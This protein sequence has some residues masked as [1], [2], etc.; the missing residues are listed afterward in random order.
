MPRIQP[1]PARRLVP[2]LSLL[3]LG[4]CASAVGGAIVDVALNAARKTFLG[5]ATENYGEQY[6]SDFDKLLTAL[7][8]P[9]EDGAKSAIAGQGAPTGTPPAGS[10]PAAAGAAPAPA[11]AGGDPSAP[12]WTPPPPPAPLELE[13]AILKEEL[14]DGRSIAMP[15]EDGEV[16]FDR[17]GTNGRGDN[18]KLTFRAN[19][20]CWVYVIGVDGTGW[21]STLFP[22]SYSAELNPVQP[23]KLYEMPEGRAWVT[24]DS[25][26]G[27]EHVYFVASRWPR[28]DLEDALR[29]VAANVRDVDPTRAPTGPD[30]EQLAMVESAAPIARGFDSVRLSE[31]EGIQTSDGVGH[32]VNVEAFLASTSADHIVVTRWFRHQ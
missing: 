21:A 15:V 29:Q 2:A 6:S 27:V 26:R 23:G 12:G 4:A 14:V 10:D 17:F 24:L 28:T 13:V 25:Y 8:K 30:G 32:A 9:V 31:A 11:A 5:V 3:A 7:S 18:L 19:Q 16:L 22:S 20:S 1:P